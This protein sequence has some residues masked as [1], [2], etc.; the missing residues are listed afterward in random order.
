[1]KTK[2]KL[3]LR[4]Y[5]AV[6]SKF[7]VIG[8]TYG[9][10]IR[11]VTEKTYSDLFSSGGTDAVKTPEGLAAAVYLLCDFRE[12]GRKIKDACLLFSASEKEVRSILSA[13][14]T[15]EE[16][17][18]EQKRELL[19]RGRFGENSAAVQEEPEKNV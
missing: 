13:E 18:E 12:A 19:R 6:A 5:A 3:F 15:A 17:A 7:A 16:A 8:D 1:G 14:E 2:K 9:R 10:K 4:G 11:R